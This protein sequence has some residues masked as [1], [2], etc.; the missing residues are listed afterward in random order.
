[1]PTSTNLNHQQVASLCLS[2]FEAEF[3]SGRHDRNRLCA[4]P[5]RFL[6]SAV[7]SLEDFP[8]TDC[9][10]LASHLSRL[11]DHLS[12]SEPHFLPPPLPVHGH[13]PASPAP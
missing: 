7:S 6:A 2:H 4:A 8:C 10:Q 11:A 1:M 5:I 9:A 12:P 3:W 13:L